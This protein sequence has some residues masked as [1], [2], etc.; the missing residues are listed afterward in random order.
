MDGNV[1]CNAAVCTI[2][3]LKQ[4]KEKRNK[5]RQE[6]V[7]LDRKYREA[8]DLLSEELNKISAGN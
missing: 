7:D 4:L 6:F 2:E 3:Q 5:A 1:S 8:M